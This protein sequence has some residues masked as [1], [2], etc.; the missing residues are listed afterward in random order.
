MQKDYLKINNIK[1][2]NTLIEIDRNCKEKLNLQVNCRGKL[3]KPQNS[4]EQKLLLSLQ[5]RSS[6]RV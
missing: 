4:D 1:M 2:V 6:P 3:G 5:G